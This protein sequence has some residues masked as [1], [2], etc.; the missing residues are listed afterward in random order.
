[1]L[2]GIIK[3]TEGI[4]SLSGEEFEG[5]VP[6][7][8]EILRNL[9]FVFQSPNLLPWR[10]VR[11]N[12]ELPLE[13]FDIP[14]DNGSRMI[15]ELM[16][17]AGLDQISESSSPEE[18]SESMR[19]RIGVI[20]AMVHNPDILLMDEPFGSLDAIKREN[21]DLELLSIW[22]NSGKTI[23]FVTHN[24]EEAVLLSSRIFVMST[25]PGEIEKKV[26]IELPRPRTLDMID[27]KK[28]VEYEDIVT[29]T[30][31]ELELEVVE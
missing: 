9:G 11:S 14:V 30:I 5:G 28:F 2:G 24:I 27:N 8:K 12:L 1:M 20:R 3:P 19:Q 16:S 25:N 10:S 4:I 29:N 6:S 31:G 22:R 15:D 21:L 23:V 26:E 18:L 17:M 13:V 7:K